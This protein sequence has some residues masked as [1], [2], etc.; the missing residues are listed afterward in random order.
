MN[1]FTHL[2][3]LSLLTFIGSFLA[4]SIP[5][6]FSL[7]PERLRFVS[8]FGAGL[9]VGTALSVI[10]PEGVETLYSI[11]LQ[12][13]S[14]HDVNVVPTSAGAHDQLA[15]DSRDPAAEEDE[16]HHNKRDRYSTIKPR[17]VE[18]KHGFEAHKYIGP[19]LS[20]GFIFMF[21]LEHLGPSQHPHTT[22]AVLADT[23]NPNE[24]K[25]KKTMA[26]TIGLL[27]HCAADGIALGAAASADRSNLEFIVFLAIILHKAPSAFG[28]VSFLM[29]EGHTRRSVRQ[30]LLA[31]SASVP[32][33]AVLTY[34][35]LHSV[36][37]VDNTSTQPPST[38]PSLASATE[39]ND[40][41]KWTGI[42]LLFS[43]GT[44]LYVATVHILPEIYRP[45]ELHSHRAGENG[46][47]LTTRP[48]G[49][50]DGGRMHDHHSHGEKS[51]S[52]TQILAW[53]LGALAP[54]VLAIEHAH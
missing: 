25:P 1:P 37:A 20:L 23:P 39:S 11:Q 16:H 40:M 6:A 8:T 21:L 27:V 14:K 47:L 53:V 51:L 42:L 12:E 54:F 31:F 18:H 26:A 9:L 17:T 35:L 46:I 5:L 13:S 19:S 38:T 41:S 48:T 28:Y 10:L 22:D 32:V 34:G 24:N 52:R 50:D 3:L 29:S 33:S 7:T 44:F 36:F 43:A 49:D 15:D 2:L 45:V 4:G 30:H